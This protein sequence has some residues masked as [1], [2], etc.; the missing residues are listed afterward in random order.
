[1]TFPIPTL[2]IALPM[3]ALFLLT[4]AGTL[5]IRLFERAIILEFPSLVNQEV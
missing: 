5:D 4:S 3:T 1:M 2:Q